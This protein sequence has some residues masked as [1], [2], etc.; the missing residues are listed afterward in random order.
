MQF[1]KTQKLHVFNCRV[2]GARKGKAQTQ[3]IGHPTV[4][5]TRWGTV[6]VIDDNDTKIDAN[7]NVIKWK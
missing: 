4:V 7:L 6:M 2:E 5:T 3:A 1:G